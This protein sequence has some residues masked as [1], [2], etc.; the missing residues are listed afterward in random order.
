VTIRLRITTTEE[1]DMVHEANW[2]ARIGSALVIAAGITVA[3]GA[4]GAAIAAA[5]P[6]V[7][8]TSTCCDP[9]D[10]TFSST[11]KTLLTS[12]NAQVFTLHGK[13]PTS[14]TRSSY[15]FTF[16]GS[17]T[18]PTADA[19]TTGTGRLTNNTTLNYAGANAYT[20]RDTFT[21]TYADGTTETTK[22]VT[23][24]TRAS[25]FSPKQPTTTSFSKCR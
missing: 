14:H 6:A 2:P 25:A 10:P 18:D 21:T 24:V 13:T 20:A 1:D 11:D 12:P 19:T 7:H 23:H 17:P 16:V 22:C 15:T 5:E 8:D 9:P 3:V 4:M